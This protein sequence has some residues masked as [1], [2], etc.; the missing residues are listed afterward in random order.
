M[1]KPDLFE[2]KRISMLTPDLRMQVFQYLI[3]S[4]F[5]KSGTTRQDGGP[6]PE[7]FDKIDVE[8]VRIATGTPQFGTYNHQSGICKWQDRYWYVFS[9]SAVD[10]EVPGM[11]TMISSS[12]DLKQWSEPTCVA[13]GDVD[14][15]MWRQ[16]GGVYPHG[17]R[18]VVFVQTKKFYHPTATAGMSGGDITR[19][20]HRVG[21]F[22]STDAV[23]WTEQNV[24]DDCYWFEA[25]KLT[26]ES[27]LLCGGTLSNRPIVFLWPGDDPFEQP[28]LVP[29]PYD[30]FH[31]LDA[32]RFPYG[33]HS[34]Y[35]I[36]DG[37]IVLFMRNETDEL[38]LRVSLSEDGG[39]SWTEP[40]LSD[41][42]DSM[43][44]VSAGR[45]ADGRF[46]LVN[47]AIADLLNR[48]P[49]MISLS[50]DGYKF[51]Q[52]LLLL[53]EPTKISFPGALKAHGYQY[54]CTMVEE[55]RLI[56]TYSVNKEHMELLTVDVSKL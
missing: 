25:P 12:E 41:I 22:W 15:E 44:R 28:E 26:A 37:T 3:G 54:P 43:S 31:S 9:N 7:V 56:V 11:R 23:N 10:E 40:M 2:T 48:V 8:R 45:L 6:W 24:A 27:R 55:D 30:D 47:N 16:T 50:D 17:D 38:R 35:Q 33:E 36:D 18:L 52:Q 42:P 39:K 4:Q 1:C 21:L 20:K 14:S 49:L 53:S 46:Y 5:T 51:D 13:P 19:E 32:G 34:W 29:I